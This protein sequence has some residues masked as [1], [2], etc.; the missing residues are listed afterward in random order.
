MFEAVRTLIERA[1]A[2]LPLA[3]LIDDVHWAGPGTIALLHY[4]VRGLKQRRCLFLLTYRADEAGDELLELLRPL[5]V[6]S[7]R[8]PT[9]HRDGRRTPNAS[10][11]CWLMILGARR[12]ILSWM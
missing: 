9:D 8:K 1:S 10:A 12:P 3:I 11:L 5:I 6:T 4:L 7:I 2:R